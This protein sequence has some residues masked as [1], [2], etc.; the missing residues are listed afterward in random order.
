MAKKQTDTFIK[1]MNSLVANLNVL[2]AKVH[3]YHWYI[4]GPGFFSL[5]GK[6]EEFYNAIA[7]DLDAVAER[8]LILGEQPIAS[9]KEYLDMATI[10]ERKSE[11]IDTLESVASIKE[12]FLIVSDQI[13][14]LIELTEELED[15]VTNDMMVALKTKYDKYIWMLDSYQ[16]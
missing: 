7:L 10:K 12:D 9:L 15:D 5:H 4:K 2:Y 8:V 3:N 13:Q 6:Y 16:K 1:E 14:N 11:P